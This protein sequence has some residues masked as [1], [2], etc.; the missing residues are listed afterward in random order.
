[1]KRVA[2]LVVAIFVSLA[3]D[4]TFASDRPENVIFLFGDGMGFGQLMIAR[5]R[6]G[7]P[8]A[9]ETMPV[10][11]LVHTAPAG[12]LVTDSAAGAT[13]LATG[14][15]TKNGMCGVT[16]DGRRVPSILEEMRDAGAG[17]GFVSTGH[18]VGATAAG[19]LAHVSSRE[20]KKEISRQLLASSADVLAGGGE[21]FDVAE[22]ARRGSKIIH[23]ADLL[24]VERPPVI[25]F[26]EGLDGSL[27]RERRSS[28]ISLADAVK[29]AVTLLRTSHSRYFLFVEE[30]GIDSAG[31]DHDLARTA[32][33]VA[34]LDEAVAAALE[35]VRGDGNTLALVTA[36]HETGGLQLTAGTTAKD[37]IFKWSTDDHTGGPV[38]IF[39][40]GPGAE[41]FAGVLDNTAVHD[42]L[43]TLLL[44]ARDGAAR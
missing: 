24:S 39:A 43:R 36:D 25:A 30:D 37:A 17:I 14:K 5:L 18:L 16:P 12:G 41:A 21:Y 9:I 40:S 15:K 11:G 33:Q 20:N 13:A 27:P 44:G 26:L 32:A 38:P 29:K 8:L 35:I 2:L 28:G 4:A 22:A 19:F 42:R 1:M 23:G 3:V 6:S 10:T 34:V 31:H 7:S